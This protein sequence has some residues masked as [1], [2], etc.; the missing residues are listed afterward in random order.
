MHWDVSGLAN[1]ILAAIKRPHNVNGHHVSIDP[2]IGV[3]IED[4]LPTSAFDLVNHADIALAYAKGFG[5]GR[6]LILEPGMGED[7]AARQ[8]L[9]GD[10]AGASS[11]EES[12]SYYQP[13]IDLASGRIVAVEALARWQHPVRGLVSPGEFIPVAESCGRIVEIC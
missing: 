2:S 13:L 1:E 10:M 5:K 3:T 7:I 6:V 11:S 4:C 12:V 8:R 9:E